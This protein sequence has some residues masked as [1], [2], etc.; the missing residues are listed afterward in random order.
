MNYIE[1]NVWLHEFERFPIKDI[2]KLNIFMP[3][4]ADTI[5]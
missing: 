5:A 4:V 2:V 1:S 3:P